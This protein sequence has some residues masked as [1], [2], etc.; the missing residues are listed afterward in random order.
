M[1]TTSKES[2]PNYLAKLVFIDDNDWKPHPNADKLKTVSIDF[3]TVITGI[4]AAEGLYVYFPLECK[5]NKDFLSFTNSFRN[6]EKNV[7]K[8]KSAFFEDNCRVRAV[9][10]RS[11]KSEGYIVPADEVV[12]WAYGYSVSE[13]PSLE[14]LLVENVNVEFDT[15][16]NKK[17]L[18]K[19]VVKTKQPR[20]KKTG[21]KPKV[22]RIIEGQFKFHVDTANL[23]RNVDK[24]NLNDTISITY[25]THGSSIVAGNVLVKRKLNL[26]ERLLKRLGIRI[27]DRE[28]DLVYSSRRVIKNEYLDDPKNSSGFYNEDIWGHAVKKF[29]LKNKIPKG[30]TLYGELLGYTPTGQMIQ[31]NYDYGCKNGEMK[32]EIYRITHTTP[33]GLV[34]ELSYPQIKE[35]CDK[36]ELSPPH[37]FYHGNVNDYV[38]IFTGTNFNV[39]PPHGT[40]EAEWREE[41]VKH[42]E[43]SYNN[44]KCFLC[45]N[46]VWEEGIVLRKESLFHCESYKLKSF[47]FLQEESKQLD[48][49]ESDIESEN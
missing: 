22:S 26:L 5:I 29:E 2:N 14:G 23:R 41:L 43:D 42:L 40:D 19:Y 9:K 1:I 12:K 34:T 10:L 16:N 17:L 6:K 47:N 11:E 37:L 49:G 27:E 35:F 30:Y 36:V 25:K 38:Y 33:G 8:E 7:D 3:Q 4:D 39:P 32:L 45:K 21:R 15:I 20:P 13:S 48:K 31:K 18:E 24:I 44:K 28:Y 46:S